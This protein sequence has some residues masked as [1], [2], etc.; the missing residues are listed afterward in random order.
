[1][2]ANLFIV[3]PSTTSD[4]ISINEGRNLIIIIILVH[5]PGPMAMCICWG[6]AVGG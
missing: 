5:G 4:A 2:W 6:G 1:M 3:H